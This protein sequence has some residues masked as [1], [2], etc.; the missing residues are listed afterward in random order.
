M[1]AAKQ[2]SSSVSVV[3]FLFLPVR[4]S[5]QCAWGVRNEMRRWRERREG[6]WDGWRDGKGRE[7]GGSLAMLA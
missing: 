2:S 1:V 6:K 7:A 5:V 3:V 4:C